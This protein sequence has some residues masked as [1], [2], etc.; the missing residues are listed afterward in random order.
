MNPDATRAIDDE[1]CHCNTS[2]PHHTDQHRPPRDVPTPRV[3]YVELSDTAHDAITI[4]TRRDSTWITCTSGPD[5]VTVGPVPTQDITNALPAKHTPPRS[6]APT[7]PSTELL[8]TALAA[9]LADAQKC[10]RGRDEATARAEK[11]ERERDEARATKDMHKRRAD[12]AEGA[13]EHARSRACPDLDA[14]WRID[15]THDDRLA[16]IARAEKAERRGETTARQRDAAD[17]RTAEAERALRRLAR[18]LDLPDT[19]SVDDM[20]ARI[21]EINAGARPLSRDT[22]TELVKESETRLASAIRAL[23]PDRGMSTYR[24]ASAVFD[25]LTPPARPEGAEEIEAWLDG[26]PE[27]I[28]LD[29]DEH[30]RLFANH[31]AHMG[32]RVPVTLAERGVRAPEDGGE[33]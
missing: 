25:A 13:L 20:V 12:E 22:I 28:R 16:A 11:A 10:R 31:L 19:A 7:A 9:A 8:E 30:Q 4:T 2:N 1:P 5:E 18:A 6:P 3:D 27:S 21:E 26:M 33:R 24:I 14:H 29:G 15:E 32:F 23:Y 17:M